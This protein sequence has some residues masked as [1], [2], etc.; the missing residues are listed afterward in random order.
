DMSFTRLNEKF[1]SSTDCSD[2]SQRSNISG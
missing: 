1:M 2:P